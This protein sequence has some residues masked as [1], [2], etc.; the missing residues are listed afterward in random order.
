MSRSERIKYETTRVSDRYFKEEPDSIT[1]SRR[2]DVIVLEVESEE[3]VEYL[4]TEVK[5]SKRKETIE[6][7]I[8][9]TLQ[10]LA[11][12]RDDGTLVHDES[13]MFGDGNS[14]VLVVRDLDDE[15]SPLEEQR[16]LNILQASELESQL[17]RILN[18]LLEVDTG[19]AE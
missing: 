12:L 1:R 11:F 2:P 19:V 6:Q 7:G 18:S 9:E 10:Y 13:R 5:Y 8:E 15:T 17:P 14:G 3:T 16:L 4:I